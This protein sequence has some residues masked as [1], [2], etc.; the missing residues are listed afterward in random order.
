MV[1]AGTCHVI[2]SSVVTFTDKG[3]ISPGYG[4]LQI[5]VTDNTGSSNINVR[6][7]YID[8]DG[9]SKDASTSTLIPKGTFKDTFI[10]VILN[11]GDIGVKDVADVAVN[12]GTAGDAFE[13]HLF[14]FGRSIGAN[15]SIVESNIPET[16]T[17]RVETGKVIEECRSIQPL[18]VNPS[19]QGHIQ[20]FKADN[21]AFEPVT[22][23]SRDLIQRIFELNHAVDLE[24]FDNTAAGRLHSS[25]TIPFSRSMLEN[26]LR[27]LVK[28]QDGSLIKTAFKVLLTS[29]DSPGKDVMAEVDPDTAAY[30]VLI[31]ETVYDSCFVLVSDPVT[32]K[33]RMY[34]QYG[35][36]NLDGKQRMDPT[37]LVFERVDESRTMKLGY[38]K[39]GMVGLN[40]N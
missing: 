16:Q 39:K 15:P 9:N 8:Q 17:G 27:G 37:Y 3:S 31:K 2:S 26:I 6:V 33:V 21:D 25:V 1:L 24:W 4:W 13:L 30:W 23:S 22:L 18:G 19:I 28:D 36:L 12:G 32:K 40:I 7:T 11:D 14:Y 34:R 29:S 38:R 20:V 35:P 5:K 10:D